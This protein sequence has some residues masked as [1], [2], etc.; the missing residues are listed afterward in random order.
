[1]AV[2]L[3]VQSLLETTGDAYYCCCCK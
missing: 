2:H 3:W 1:M